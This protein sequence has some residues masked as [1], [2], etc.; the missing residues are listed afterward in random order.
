MNNLDIL[1]VAYS[2]KDAGDA[3]T[4]PQIVESIRQD[5]QEIAP[6]V[7]GPS[8]EIGFRYESVGGVGRKIKLMDNGSEEEVQS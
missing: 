3:R 1:T 7:P 4:I 2:R 5:L 8:D 6:P